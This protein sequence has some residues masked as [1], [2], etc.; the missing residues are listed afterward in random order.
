MSTILKNYVVAYIY[1]NKVKEIKNI[2]IKDD[3]LIDILWYFI[4]ILGILVIK[5]LIRKLNKKN[6]KIE[7]HLQTLIKILQ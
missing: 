2:F 4:E 1:N 5:K 3:I 6:S 7:I